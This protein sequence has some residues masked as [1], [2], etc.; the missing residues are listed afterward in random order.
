MVLLGCSRP[1]SLN[2]KVDVSAVSLK[3]F[4]ARIAAL[5]PRVADGQFA[6]CCED[7]DK[8]IV[9]VTTDDQL[10][11]HAKA[12]LKPT[13]LRFI[14][15]LFSDS[16]D[17]EAHYSDHQEEHVEMDDGS[18]EVQSRTSHHIRLACE[19]TR[20]RT[21]SSVARGLGSRRWYT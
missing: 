15:S 5:S 20:S 18:A 19:L 6:L 13:P 9:L 17:E 2:V 8:E 4:R 11:E 3:E 12:C 10:W 21:A 1:E 16:C 7:K 14:V